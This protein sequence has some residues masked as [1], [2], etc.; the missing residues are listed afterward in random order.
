MDNFLQE[1]FNKDIEQSI[2]ESE[3][4]GYN[5]KI[6]KI[7]FYETY[8]RD[9]VQLANILINK[10]QTY[11]FE[12]LY[13][14][15][16]LDLTIEARV[17]KTE[18]TSLF[19]ETTLKKA[20]RKLAQL[21]YK[22]NET[23]QEKT[24][25]NKQETLREQFYQFLL[26]EGFSDKTP[27]GNPS[28]TYDYLKRIDFVCENESL[29][30][31]SLAQNI[32]TILNDY[33]ATGIK[34][35]LGAKSHN[36]VFSALKQYKLFVEQNKKEKILENNIGIIQDLEAFEDKETEKQALIKIR[37]GH[38][39]LKEIIL[40]NKTKCDICGLNHPKLLIASHIKPW[41]KSN[42]REKLDYHN[43][44]LLCP[45]HDALFDRGLI[46]FNDNGQI[47][48]SKELSVQNRALTNIDDNICI[49]VTSEKQ[50]EY[51]QWHR[52]NIFN[53]KSNI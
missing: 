5:P 31:E 7:M 46:S 39:K 43:I 51:L 35:E 32:D 38:S 12:E 22:I 36:A 48:I 29:N 16:R 42:D 8:H 27:S 25:I 4:N 44:L 3:K 53:K 24:I 13:K 28:T 50:K 41:S 2:K 10:G 14:I 45:I 6:F 9:G 20:K 17:L 21:G 47:L 1:Q 19:D 33:G 37:I 30:W 11:G 52:K 23:I 34:A 40:R 18:F 15:G 49:N 26:K